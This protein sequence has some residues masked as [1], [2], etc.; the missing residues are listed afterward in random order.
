MQLKALT[1]LLLTTSLPLLTAAAPLSSFSNAAD[2]DTAAL[3]DIQALKTD[4]HK[5][6]TAVQNWDGELTSAMPMKTD[7]TNAQEDIDKA[8]KDA[9]DIDSLSPDTKEELAKAMRQLKPEAEG[10]LKH[11]VEK[12]DILPPIQE[13]LIKM[14]TN[15]RNPN[16][17]SLA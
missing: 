17:K 11:L 7:A 13:G 9:K 1:T 16:S 5:L 15:D 6:D 12:V 4:L 2:A 8:L 14:L 3:E 10:A